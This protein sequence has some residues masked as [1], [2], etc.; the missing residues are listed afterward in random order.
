[1]VVLAHTHQAAG[2]LPK[3]GLAGCEEPEIRPP[4]SERD[5]ERL[6]LSYDDVG[7]AFARECS[8]RLE[9]S[10]RQRFGDDDD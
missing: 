7:A 1:M 5:T 6:G 8:R 10:K 2:N 4:E 3:I 9:E